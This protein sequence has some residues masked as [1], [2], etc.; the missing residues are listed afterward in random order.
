MPPGQR[1]FMCVIGYLRIYGVPSM[2]KALNMTMA[3]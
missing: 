2:N 3:A 1:S